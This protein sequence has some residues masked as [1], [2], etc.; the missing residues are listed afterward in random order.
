M[1][2]PLITGYLFIGALSGP[3]VLDVIHKSDVGRLGYVTQFALAFIAF[4]AGAEL[5][6]PELRSLFKRIVYMTTLIT[7][8]TFIVVVAVV[9]AMTSPG[10]G[11][12]SYLEPLTSGCRLSIA[13]IFAAIMVA[14]SPASA[15]AVVKETR[16]KGVF[17]STLLG[18]TVLC[19]VYVLLGFTL[20]TTIA[21]TECS[22]DQPFSA[23]ALGIMAATIVASLLIGWALGYVLVALMWFKRFPARYLILP[24]GLGVFVACHSITEYSVRE[25][26][27]IINLEPLLICIMAG[28]ICTN[29]SAHRARFITVMQQAGPYVFLPFFTLTGASLDLSVMAASFGVAL[30]IACIRATCIFFGSYMGG[31]LAG[32]PLDHS[33]FIWMTL[34]TQAGVSLGLASE[35]GMSYPGWGRSVQSTIIAIV[36]VNQITGPILFKI[37]LRRVGEAG[38]ASQDALF[39]EDAEIPTA[40][41]LGDTTAGTSTS[42]RL[43]VKTWRVAMVAA[44][45]EGETAARDAVATYATSR[46]ASKKSAPVSLVGEVTAVG[47]AASAA[48]RAALGRATDAVLGAVGATPLED[49]D[50]HHGPR[51]PELEDLFS[52]TSDASTASALSAPISLNDVVSSVRALRTLPS[53]AAAAG[54]SAAAAA[55]ATDP[56]AARWA[57]LIARV[58]STPSLAAIVITLPQTPTSDAAVFSLCDAVRAALAAAPKRSTLHSVKVVAQVRSPAWASALKT[59]GVAPVHAFSTASALASALVRAP[60]GGNPVQLLN[61]TADVDLAK[62]WFDVSVEGPALAALAAPLQASDGPSPTDALLAAA[63][64]PY[65][66]EPTGA[67]AEGVE[68]VAP[69]ARDDYLSSFDSMGENAGDG[70]AGGREVEFASASKKDRAEMYGS[71]STLLN[72]ADAGVAGK[73]SDGGGATR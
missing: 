4:S 52:V 40:L 39:D 69:W 61:V 26:P 60:T 44:S 10:A 64:A 57:P 58:T 36:L 41:V 7:A 73:N 29:T 15:I 46:R 65:V 56:L 32:A 38:K 42:V 2:L 43:L 24:L 34:L 33:K 49:D 54:A 5:Y 70:V 22:S 9:Y 23:I 68:P 3:N 16:A 50:H 31:R 12:L 45:A 14:R 30:L 63:A 51:A 28:Y 27:H 62:A 19:D 72:S 18:V 11:M 8:V 21:E 66:R 1:G 59:I 47:V 37:A 35:I 67:N 55:A 48:A 6:L 25:L 20:T 13:G 53:A 71:V 17:T